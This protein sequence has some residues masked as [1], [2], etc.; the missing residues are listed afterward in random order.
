[1]TQEIQIM[2]PGPPVAMHRPKFSRSNRLDGKGTRAIKD[3][4]DV[5]YQA[6]IGMA[7]T[8]AV[9]R[10]AHEHQKPWDGTG[11]WEVEADFH[12]PD[13]RRRDLDNCLKNAL[14]GLSGVAFND[15]TQ[16]VSVS[17]TKRLDRE[18]PKTFITVRRVDHGW[19]DG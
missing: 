9:Q 14:D 19:L 2:L 16:V 3:K 15:D 11:E 1:M 4:K 17:C 8:A 18:R 7:A 12:L 6:A 5:E 10:W 13:L